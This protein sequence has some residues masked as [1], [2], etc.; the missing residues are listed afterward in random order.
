MTALTDLVLHT[1]Y[2]II[3]DIVEPYLWTDEDLTRYANDAIVEAC[4]RA[5]LLK[6]V[7]TKAIVAA[8]A[9]YAIDVSI[10]Q[11]YTAKLDLATT[12][13]IQTTDTELS[14]YYG[15]Q[16]RTRSGTPT[17]Y[18]R[19]G[20]SLTLYPSPIVNDT[21]VIASSNVPDAGF[22]LAV[23][24]DPIYYNALMYYIAYLA[25]RT[26]V[27]VN[28]ILGENRLQSPLKALEYLALFDAQ[29]GTKKTAKFQQL[30]QDT[31][32]YGSITGGRMC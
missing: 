30:S 6:R 18:V 29:F 32:L 13:L 11:I 28:P 3:G 17:H 2:D 26:S 7:T 15:S 31:P 12:P 19:S 21:L 8:T 1:R 20:P 25:F 22:D 4:L 9:T 24:I 10:K 14:L 5:P 23:D 16:W 27:D